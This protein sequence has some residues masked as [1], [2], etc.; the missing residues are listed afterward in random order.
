MTWE[1]SWEIHDYNIIYL[2]KKIQIHV[3]TYSISHT[4]PRKVKRSEAYAKFRVETRNVS[5]RYNDYANSIITIYLSIYLFAHL[6][7]TFHAQVID[8]PSLHEFS[9]RLP[10]VAN[11]VSPSFANYSKTTRNWISIKLDASAIIR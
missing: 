7:S 5:S 6:T 4:A 1:S 10:N 8:S 2:Y 9:N 3:Y 11:E